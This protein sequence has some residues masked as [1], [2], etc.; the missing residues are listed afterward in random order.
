MSIGHL[1]P[2]VTL[3][4]AVADLNAIGSYLVKTY[5]KDERPGGLALA[6]PNLLGDQFAPGVQAFIGGLML[7]AGLILLAACAA[8]R[9]KEIAMRLA[10][11]SSRNRILRA[12]FTEAVMISLAGGS[13]GM[14]MSVVFLRWL[15][16]GSRLGISP[17][18][19]Q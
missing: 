7:L 16:N 10:L 6:R 9:A 5:P 12:L 8:D 4:A 14:W 13:V 18:I 17:C 3:A 19:H 2:G 15:S 1:K 11:G